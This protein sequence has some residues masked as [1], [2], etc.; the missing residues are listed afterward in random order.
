MTLR[1]IE[2]KVNALCELITMERRSQLVK[3]RLDC[4]ANMQAAFTTYKDGNKYI[5]IDSNGSGYF[6]IEKATGKIYGI[7]A[8]GVIHRG[9]EYGTLDTFNE[10]YWGHYTPKR[11]QSLVE[12]K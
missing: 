3:D 7:K 1:Q 4:E 9:H 10:F 6:M 11:K 5:K 2:D 8:Y 12:V